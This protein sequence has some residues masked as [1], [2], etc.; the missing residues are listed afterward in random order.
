MKKFILLLIIP[1]LSFGQNKN[2]NIHNVTI[3][4]KFTNYKMQ[5]FIDAVDEIITLPEG[6]SKRAMLMYLLAV[7]N[8]GHYPDVLDQL[9]IEIATNDQ[10]IEL[11]E[12]IIQDFK[13]ATLIGRLKDTIVFNDLLIKYNIVE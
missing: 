11:K 5:N 4:E 3:N 12:F 8:K 10:L 9:D 1:L 7:V 13:K 2:I 6:T